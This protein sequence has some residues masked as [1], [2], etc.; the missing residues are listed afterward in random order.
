L[1]GRA[2]CER[3]L[4][5]FEH[6]EYDKAIADFKKIMEDGTQTAQYKPASQGLATT[7]VAMGKPEEAQKYSGDVGKGGGALMF[8]LQTAFSA[9]NAT[10]DAAKRE[11]Y[12]KQIVDKIKSVEDNKG[13]WAIAIAAVGKYVQNPVAEFGSSSDPFEKWLLA[14]VLLS[15]K[16]D[17]GAAKYYVEAARGSGKYAKGYKYAAEIYDKQKRYDM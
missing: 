16:D 15:K 13:D 9:E 4:G 6:A 10:H 5:K 1:L 8:Q 11:Q 17:S 3:E 12:H 7:L 14:N 2:Y